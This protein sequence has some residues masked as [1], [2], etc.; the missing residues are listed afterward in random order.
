MR[1]EDCPG[2]SVCIDSIS[3]DQDGFCET[4]EMCVCAGIGTGGVGGTGAGGRGGAVTGGSAGRGGGGTGGGTTT[5]LGEPCTSSSQCGTGLTCLLS[6]GLPSGDGPPNGLCTFQC[7]ADDEC[8][9]FAN[10]AFCVV[11]EDDAAG[12]TLNYCILGCTGGAVGAPKCRLRNDFACGILSTTPSTRSCVDTNDCPAEQVCYAEVEGDPTVCH[13]MTT[14]CIPVCRADGDCAS[15]QFCD[16]SSGFCT[17]MEPEGLPIGALC[18]P[19]AAEDPCNGFCTPTDATQTQGTCSAFCSAS[20][21]A[22]GCGWDG[23]G[24]PPEA[25][26]LYA[27]II[28]RDGAGG[29]SLAESDLM[30]CGQLCDCNDDCPADI[31]L[32]MDENAV[33]PTASIQAIFGRDGYCRPLLTGETTA[34]SLACP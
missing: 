15:G 34:D 18:D 20:L 17:A 13:D 29:I 6:D 1:D 8:L 7:A 33:D 19:A 24:A 3:G 21:D 16:H 27:T 4:G 10:E 22:T 31:E 32:C 11:F 26:C 14:G 12:N 2:S 28:S 30:L 25:G 5:A 23:T 9:E